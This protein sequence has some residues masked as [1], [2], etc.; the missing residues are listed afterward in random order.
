ML[1]EISQRRIGRALPDH[2]VH[3]DQTLEDDGPGRV[4][5]AELQ[6]P[7]D[8]SHA[9]FAGMRGNEDVLDVLRFRGGG[10]WLRRRQSSVR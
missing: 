5:Q 1:C 4:P 8:L 6:R 7:E 9:S 3:R 10:L 2:Q